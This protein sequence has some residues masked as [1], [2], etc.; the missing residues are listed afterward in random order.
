MG[1]TRAVHLA[2]LLTALL[3][4]TVPGMCFGGSGGDVTIDVEI[5]ATPQ[6]EWI[7]NIA[8]NP[9]D[10]EFA[11]L[12]HT[13]FTPEGGEQKMYSLHAQ[14][15][16]PEGKLLGDAITLVSAGP[17]RR[18]LPIVAHN[19]PA[20]RY[21][22]SFTMEQK[23]TAQDPF[24]VMLDNRGNVLS[25]PIC[26]SASPTTA[27]HAVIGF[28]SKRRQYLVAYNDSPK[29]TQDVLGV[30]L[31]EKGRIV[32]QDFVISSAK[33][34]QINPYVCYNPIDDTYLVNWED[35][36]HVKHWKEPSNIYGA[37]LDWQGSILVDDIPMVEDYGLGDE[38]D[39]RHNTITHNPRRNEFLVCWTDGRPSLKNV[40]VVGRI[41]TSKGSLAGPTF[42]IAD[43]QGPQIFPQAAYS[44]KRDMYLVIWDDGRNDDPDRYWRKVENWDVYATWLD[45]SGKPAGSHIPV[46]QKDGTQRFSRVAYNPG[47]DRFLI[48]WREFADEGIVP[49]ETSGHLV[50]SGGNIVGKIYV[51]APSTRGKSPKRG[52]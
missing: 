47:A 8:Y 27:S 26:L 12:W 9:V 49:K 18:I 28:N 22:V 38:G 11:V 25:G 29:G 17:E 39:Q 4:V 16:S 24:A 21:M 31:D 48:A 1:K 51:P 7:P 50:D 3:S 19:A 35:F 34:D 40:G 14:R 15:V 41:I 10:N 32:K 37:L 36:R 5:A 43:V 6:Q 13:T 45:P 44:E 30:I 33:G 42:V 20:N 23:E 52:E 46:C 2:L